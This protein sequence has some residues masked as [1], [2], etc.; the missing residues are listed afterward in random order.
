M[1]LTETG[2]ITTVAE[3]GAGGA[4]VAGTI[5]SNTARSNVAYRVVG[6]IQITEATAGTWASAPTQI[7]G[8]GGLT[9][10]SLS[11]NVS[12]DAPMFACRAWVRFN[13]SGVVAVA[14][15]GNVSSVTDN[16]GTGDYTIN[17]SQ[18]MPDANYVFSGTCDNLGVNSNAIMANTANPPTA[19]A[20]R[21]N[22]RNMSTG[23]TN[24][25]SLVAVAIFR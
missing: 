1:R 23:G 10:V 15:S 25:A 17:F 20:L 4:D 19:S 16:G 7:V 22:V 11:M 13:G 24:D 5:Y 12:G 6:Y 9:G 8:Y 3:G 18:A 2:V 14:A 21:F